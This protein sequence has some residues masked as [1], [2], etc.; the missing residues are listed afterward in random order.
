VAFIPFEVTG[1]S[2]AYFC[3]HAPSLQIAEDS[4]YGL[5]LIRDTIASYASLTEK[6]TTDDDKLQTWVKQ[7]SKV[8]GRN[9]SPY[10]KKW[11]W[12]VSA[13]TE[14]AL[15]YLPTWTPT[16]TGASVPTF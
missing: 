9:L 15:A 3:C 4:G 5:D 12:P 7:Q 1:P 16:A 8:L 10:F 11:G 13:A 2:D 6:P 14:S